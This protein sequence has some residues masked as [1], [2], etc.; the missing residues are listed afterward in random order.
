MNESSPFGSMIYL[1]NMLIFHSY[2]NYFYIYHK[3]KYLLRLS[4]KKRCEKKNAGHHV[5]IHWLGVAS[6]RPDS[7]SWAGEYC[8]RHV[9]WRL[10]LPSRPKKGEG[11]PGD[12]WTVEGY[13]MLNLYINCLCI[14]IYMH[15]PKT[16]LLCSKYAPECRL[17]SYLITYCSWTHPAPEYSILFLFF[18][19]N[20]FF[21][22]Q[23][24]NDFWWNSCLLKFL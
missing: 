24:F 20:T 5:R 3:P 17:P 11:W 4:I 1:L 22:R 16:Y 7:S 10:Y 15:P 12:C 13:G 21:A 19:M 9:Q 8:G 6:I 14:Y 2:M 18:L 23:V